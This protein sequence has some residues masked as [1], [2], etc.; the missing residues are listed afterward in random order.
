MT[1]HQSRFLSLLTAA[2]AVAALIQAWPVVEDR[3]LKPKPRIVYFQADNIKRWRFVWDRLSC[4]R[5]F[6]GNRSLWNRD[7]WDWPHWLAS[8]PVEHIRQRG[9]AGKDDGLDRSSFDSEVH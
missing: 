9:L 5:P 3:W 4:G 2:A 7:I 1:S 8:D 6:T